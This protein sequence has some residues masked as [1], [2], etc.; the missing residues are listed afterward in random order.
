[1]KKVNLTLIL[2]LALVIPLTPG[3]APP[4]SAVGIACW[5]CNLSFTY[6]TWGAHLWYM[7]ELAMCD[8]LSF[9]QSELC[10]ELVYEIRDLDLEICELGRE[11]CLATCDPFAE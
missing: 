3:A 10:R 1:M 11:I 2:G 5:T 8:E 7:E 4:L 6:C 9:P